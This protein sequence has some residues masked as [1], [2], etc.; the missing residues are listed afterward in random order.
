MNKQTMRSIPAAAA[1]A[2]ALLLGAQVQAQTNATTPPGSTNSKD[3]VTPAPA[4]KTAARAGAE[5]QNSSGNPVAS[6]ATQTPG[7]T[8]GKDNVSPEPAGGMAKSA[9]DRNAAKQAKADK[10]AA[11]K[12][13][14]KARVASNGN[15]PVDGVDT[16]KGG[17]K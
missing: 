6:S 1:I 9:D 7:T 10:R 16:T 4:G 17:T 12:G 3:A 11:K 2:A 13:A 8:K 14:R 15:P 5:A